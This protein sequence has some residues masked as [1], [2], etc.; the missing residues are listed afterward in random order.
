MKDGS[1]GKRDNYRA[2]ANC[3]RGMLA[4][5]YGEAFFLPSPKA[6]ND[7]ELSMFMNLAYG[8]SLYAMYII[9]M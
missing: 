9:L 6:C 3:E 2:H 5:T 8:N 4:F 7:S 1:D